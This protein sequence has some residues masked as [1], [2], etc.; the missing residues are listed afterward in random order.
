MARVVFTTFGSFGDLHPYLAI[1]LRLKELGISTVIASCPSYSDKVKRLGLSFVPMQPSEPDWSREIELTK[2]LLHERSSVETLFRYFVLNNLRESYDDLVEALKPNDLLVSHPL[3][4]VTR[5]AAERLGLKWLS[6]VLQPMG[7][8]SKYDRPQLA[9]VPFLNFLGRLGP[10]A[11]S[12]S[13]TMLRAY[14][15]SWLRPY[16]EFRRELHLSED[17][18]PLFSG[19]HA[20]LGVL[21]MFSEAFAARQK[22]WPAQ[23]IMTGF[24]F[25]QETISARP[26]LDRFIACGPKPLLFTLGSAAIHD[27]QDF[28]EES[29][30]ACREL[31][32]RAIL[33]VGKP[34]SEHYEDVGSDI[35]VSEYV[36]FSYVFK[37]CSLIVHSGGIGTVA[38]CMAQGVPQ[39]VV[40]FANDQPDNAARVLKLGF[41]LTINRF[42]YRYSNVAPLLNTLLT[43]KRYESASQLV[44]AKLARENGV[45]KASATI[46]RIIGE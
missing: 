20:K 27:A 13:H 31:G 43:D 16:F 34:Y 26:E 45:D 9:A 33:L 15:K 28:F 21:A 2:A 22:D 24:P 35:F 42:K 39:L 19:Q 30:K 7:F 11:F 10:G 12:L 41:G 17:Q 5:L 1:A 40:P 8:F 46:M 23:T 36:P 18:D 14:T 37:Q 32:R 6:T 25:L 29:I 4:L 3:T 44:C 38:Q